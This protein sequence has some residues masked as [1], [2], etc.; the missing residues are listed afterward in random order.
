MK[1]LIEL[2]LSN[3]NSRFWYAQE[4]R[5]LKRYAKKRNWD[6]YRFC[7]IIAIT[8]P[9]VHILRNW[10]LA[11]NYMAGEK[12]YT[13]ALPLVIA[14]LKYYEQTG[15]IRGPKTSSFALCLQGDESAVVLDVYMARILGCDYKAMYKPANYE[16]LCRR[17]EKLAD[18]LGY[19]PAQTQACLWLNYLQA[20]NRSNGLSYSQLEL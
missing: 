6:F 17:I 4:K 11:C 19:T 16:R 7:N 2:A 9:R 14:G 18:R 20:N 1:K 12:F 13:P 3:P 5:F 10:K 8:S 15:V